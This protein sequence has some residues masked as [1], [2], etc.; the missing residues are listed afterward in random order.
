VLAASVH[1]R[2]RGTGLLTRGDAEID[3]RWEVALRRY[4]AWHGEGGFD[5]VITKVH[6]TIPIGVVDLNRANEVA[7]TFPLIAEGPLS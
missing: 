4:S 3:R 1:C 2:V 5:A 6:W 7:G